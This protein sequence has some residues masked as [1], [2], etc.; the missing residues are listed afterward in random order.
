MF[1]KVF[2][3]NLLKRSTISSSFCIKFP[4]CLIDMK[5]LECVILLEQ[6][7]L[8]TSQKFLLDVSFLVERLL[9]NCLK[10]LIIQFVFFKAF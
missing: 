4:L 7:E 6:K 1:S 8:T 2:Q 3:Q 10:R 5:S 9:R